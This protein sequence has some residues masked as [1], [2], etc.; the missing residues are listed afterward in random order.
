MSST[1]I[2]STDCSVVKIFSSRNKKQ[3]DVAPLYMVELRGALAVLTFPFV[4]CSIM[5]IYHIYNISIYVYRIVSSL[6]SAYVVFLCCNHS[7]HLQNF[8]CFEPL[9]CAHMLTPF[10]KTTCEAHSDIL[11]SAPSNGTSIDLWTH[12]GT[13]PSTKKTHSKI[14]TSIQSSKPFS[15]LSL[16]SVTCLRLPPSNVLKVWINSK[17]EV[18]VA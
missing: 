3:K 6:R 17:K 1:F 11:I 5:Y 9:K 8:K 13:R 14:T 4:V 16:R 15:Y 18:G 10:E 7:G 2:P 12:M